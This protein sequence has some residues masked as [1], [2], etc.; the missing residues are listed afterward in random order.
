MFSDYH[1]MFKPVC[2]F[3]RTSTD[4]LPYGDHPT[5]FTN[6]FTDSYSL[7]HQ[8]LY[9]SELSDHQKRKAE[10]LC[11]FVHNAYEQFLEKAINPEW[12]KK[13]IEEREAHIKAL[14]ERPQVEQRTAAWYAQ[15]ATVLT[16]SEFSTLFGSARGR[17]S[18][19]QAKANPP[20]PSA[21][22]AV[23]HRSE[24]IGPLNWGVRFEPVVKQILVKKWSCE[25]Q[26]MGR[27]IH[28]KDSFLAASPDGLIVKSPHKDKVCRLLEIKCPYTRK[29]GGD[30]PFDYWVQMQIQ[31]E[32]ADIDECEYVECELV[33]KRPG[34]PLVDLS[35]CKM[36]GN[37]YLWEKDGALA[38]EYDQVEREGWT[39]VEEIPW[40]LHKYHNKV[41]RRDRAWYESTHIWRQAFWTDVARVK[42]GLELLEP[43]TPMSPKIKV[44]VCKIQD[45]SD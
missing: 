34:Q 31:M 24:D 35:G 13:T 44:N 28:A 38:Y 15:A 1:E 20:P 43:V 40:G 16:A 36:T 7:L 3:V 12:T 9:E 42:E 5:L 33:S 41:V 4:I 25:I 39:L 11:E 22:R 19:V 21:P 23:A 10:K 45:E 37:M 32:V 2:E 8:S 18:L 30:I 14:C 29:V 26:E 17:A 27:L 6:C